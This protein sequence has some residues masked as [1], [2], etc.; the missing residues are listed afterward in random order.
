[1]VRNWKQAGNPPE[2]AGRYWC[3]IRTL[4]DL[5]FSFEQSNCGWNPWDNRW[6]N[7]IYNEPFTVIAWTELLD[8]PNFK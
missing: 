2:N 4:S 7:E 3:Y 8:K 6:Y 1:M 5:G